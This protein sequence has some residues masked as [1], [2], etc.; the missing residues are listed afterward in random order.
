MLQEGNIQIERNNNCIQANIA[1]DMSL[2]Q[3]FCTGERRRNV[4]R[5]YLFY[6]A[7][8]LGCLRRTVISPAVIDEVRYYI[9]VNGTGDYYSNM[10]FFM[11]YSVYLD[12]ANYSIDCFRNTFI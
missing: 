4:K 2:F 6:S 10:P 8:R 3:T 7:G 1:T 12:I 11:K 9:I 5:K